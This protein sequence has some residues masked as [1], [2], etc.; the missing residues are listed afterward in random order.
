VES[1]VRNILVKLGFTTR[2]Q[3]AAWLAKR[4]GP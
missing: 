1:H 3:V 4:E 2:T